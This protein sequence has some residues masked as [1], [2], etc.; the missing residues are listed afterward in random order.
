MAPP[1]WRGSLLPLG[2]EAALWARLLASASQ[3]SGSKLPRHRKSLGHGKRSQITPRLACS[4]T[5]RFALS[6]PS[7]WRELLSIL[8][9]KVAHTY[10]PV[11][12]RPFG[13]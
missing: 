11:L 5:A 6:P 13:P 7:P 12:T 2:C 9:H 1:L 3:P 10:R 4:F 8:R